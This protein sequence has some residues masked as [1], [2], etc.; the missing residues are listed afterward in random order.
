MGGLTDLIELALMRGV[1]GLRDRGNR[2]AP[3]VPAPGDAL[4]LGSAQPLG[5]S[6]PDGDLRLTAEERRRHLYVLGATGSGKTNLLVQLIGSDVEAGR[7]AIVLDL[8]GDLV[9]RVLLRLAA[10]DDP[11]LPGR[12]RLL[13]LRDEAFVTGFNPLLGKGEI[14][15]RAYHLLGVIRSQA[16]S[17]GVQ[18]E[19]TARNGL[20]ALAE[21]RL[22]LLELEP[23]LT[24]DAVRAEVLAGVGDP[25]VRSFFGRYD[26]LS[27]DKRLAWALP[28]LNKVTPLLAIPRI[29]LMLGSSRSLDWSEVIDGASGRIVLVSLAVDRLHSAAYLVGGLLVSAIQ[30]AAMARADIPEK[31]RLPVSLYIDE[32]ETMA[33]ESFSAIV[34]EGRRFG[35]SLTL[36]HQNLT[37]VPA[38]L[39]SVLRNNVHTQIYFQTG[40]TD[41][42][43]LASEISADVPKEELKKAL[44]SLKVGEAFVNRRGEE[45]LLVRTRHSPDPKADAAKLGALKAASRAAW[46]RP[47]VYVE[48]EIA[49]RL[50]PPA[51]EAPAPGTKGGEAKEVR[52][53]RKPSF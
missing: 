48:R 13:D 36:S 44:L 35:L 1:N 33:S 20:L 25:Y 47:K 14:H 3:E 5:G 52:H 27:A 12:L 16:E 41:A 21:R 39:R 40:A 28:V 18:L 50:A 22:S 2:R 17:W 26:A 51:R 7:S 42:A 24:D 45:T 53:G 4:S 37:Q 32:F 8:R 15:A 23:L 9:D 10:S 11:S 46:S 31:R 29:R 6:G 34:A 19:E 43:E 30:N 38:G 49:A